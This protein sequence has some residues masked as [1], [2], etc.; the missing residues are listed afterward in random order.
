MLKVRKG[1]MKIF[2]I[3][4]TTNERDYFVEVETDCYAIALDAYREEKRDQAKYRESKL[5]ELREFIAPIGYL[6]MDPIDRPFID[7]YETIYQSKLK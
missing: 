1:E 4:W 5:V 7:S 3:I 6:E 2:E